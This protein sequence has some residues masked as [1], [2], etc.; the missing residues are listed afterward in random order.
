MVLV[1]LA[2][3]VPL[4]R[5]SHVRVPLQGLSSFAS[6]WNAPTEICMKKFRVPLDLRFFD[7]EG[8]TLS[9]ARGQNITLF[10]TDR[11]GYYPSIHPV[12]GKIYNG[13]IPQMTNMHEHLRKA[14]EDLTHYI[15]STTR[16]GLAVIDWEDWRPTWI[17]NWASKE[18]YKT[19]SIEF[20]LQ[21]DLRLSQTK[22]ASVAK[23]QFEHAA[24]HLM[25]NTLRIGKSMRPRHL[26]GFYLFPNCQN[27]DY[28]QNPHNYT[29]RCPEIEIL[30]NDGLHWL[31]KESTALFPNMYLETALR[32]S[33]NAALFSRHRIQEAKRL[34]KI[35]NAAHSLPVYMYNRPVFTDDTQEY[36]SKVDLVH[37]IGESAAL[38][39]AGFVMW[40]DMNLTLS[41]ETCTNLNNFIVN[42][43]NPYIINVTLASKLCSAALCQNNGVCT[44]KHWNTN[45][46]LHLN[47]RNMVIGRKDGKYFVHG[48]PTVE[49]LNHFYENFECQCYTGRKCRR[50]SPLRHINVCIRQNIC[51][52]TNLSTMSK[53]NSKT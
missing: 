51:I 53:K 28:K 12:T 19:M 15:P 40:G 38:G 39:T 24:K 6:I 49:D 3:V 52:N 4:C 42:T 11:L 14:K 1:M 48:N 50:P 31:W 29:G 34:S 10:Y 23:T 21:K 32:S 25:L 26:W 44:R 35:A 22:A 13:G 41:K 18:V 5:S 45:T 8:S 46:Y 27:Y 36:L 33:T 9:C 20:A 17:R 37:T 2:L 7:M 30:R 47:K 43:L 16:P